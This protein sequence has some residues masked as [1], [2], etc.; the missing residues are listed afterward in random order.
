[1]SQTIL[2]IDD[3]KTI[4]WSLSEALQESGY[5][6]IDAGTAD[7]GTKLF[8]EKSADLVLLDLK[9]PGVSGIDVLKEIK[10]V[11]PTVPIIMMTAYGEVETAVEAMKNAAYDFILK[12]F[13]LEKLKVTIANAL[14]AHRLKNE[15]AYLNEKTTRSSVFNNF[16]GQ[17]RQ[18]VEIFDK[19]KK[20]GDSKAN[21]ILITGES[22]AGKELV[23]RAIHACSYLEP[24]PFMEINCA[25][26]PET[27]LESELFGHEK[28]AF[29][30][31]KT[32]KKGL[33][34]LAEGGTLFLDEIGEMGITL[35]ARLLRVLENK[36]FRRVGGVQDLHVNT[37][38]ISATNKD[39][40]TAIQEKDFRKD[41]YYRLKVIPIHIPPLR[42]RKEDIPLLVNHFVDRF[43]KEL[44][45]RIRPVKREVMEALLT[46]DWPG[47]VRELK[48]VIERAMLLDAEDEILIEHLPP[49]IQGL[50]SEERKEEASSAFLASFFPMTLR[51]V[52]R[53]QIQ[54]TLEQTNGNKSRAAS[55]LGIS[56][57]TLRE[58]LKSFQPAANAESVDQKK[59]RIKRDTGAGSD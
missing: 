45:K 59:T 15:I 57:Q 20:I 44:G 50:A 3:E 43:N 17:S 24:R 48:N 49:E 31:A 51:E 5:E 27:L 39:L 19:V 37:R 14:E 29:T 16:I 4:R 2:I 33:V 28:G 7:K 1:M 52:E 8:K 36:T 13:A 30:D 22:G 38:I 11:D 56:R 40:Q 55:I 18:I 23:A 12:P 25:A 6:V 9:L 58:K 46:Y 42:E 53:I 26:V 41:L 21:T 35:Q 32:R 34:E 10:S 47:N 54:R